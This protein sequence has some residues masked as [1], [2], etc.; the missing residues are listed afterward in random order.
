M[1][2][3]SSSNNINA[4]S[5]LPRPPPVL[6]THTNDGTTCLYY[7]NGQL[8]VLLGNVYGYFI[9]SAGSV[10][11]SF[12]D[13]GGKSAERAQQGPTSNTN[14]FISNSYGM[15][16]LWQN[17]NNSFTTVVYDLAQS[18]TTPLHGKTMT[19][20]GGGGLGS[21]P[22]VN[23]VNTERTGETQAAKQPAA[24]LNRKK[25]THLMDKNI[26]AIISPLGYCVAYRK[27]GTP[28]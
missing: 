3:G 15:N 9:E 12:L 18:K 11:S 17:V 10:N 20:G 6:S 1:A 23:T 26:L 16:M 7:P 27:N 8:A 2:G 14:S 28:R 22:T 21:K 13:L 5:N 4:P 24:L 19:P 25:V